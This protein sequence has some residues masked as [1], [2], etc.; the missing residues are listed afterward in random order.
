MN[1]IKTSPRNCLKAVTYE[2]L[3][4]ICEGFFLL[5][6]DK[7]NLVREADHLEGEGGG[8]GGGATWE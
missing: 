1:Q 2:Q 7:F 5:P 6:P 3:V 4:F 8:G